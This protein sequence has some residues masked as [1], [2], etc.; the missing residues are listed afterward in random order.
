MGDIKRILSVRILPSKGECFDRLAT[1]QCESCH[2][3]YRDCRLELDHDVFLSFLESMSQA[4]SKALRLSKPCSADT[5]IELSYRR[6][7]IPPRHH[8]RLLIEQLKNDVIHIH[9]N[10]LR[11]E[12]AE[13]TFVQFASGVAEAFNTWATSLETEIITLY[14]TEKLPLDAINPYDEGHQLDNTIPQGFRCRNV[15]ETREHVEGMELCCQL[16]QAGF[17]MLPIAVTPIE[18]RDKTYSGD[19]LPHHRYQR[20]DGFKRYMAFK[21][22]GFMSITSHVYLPPHARPGIQRYS[23]WVIGKTA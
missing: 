11:I 6:I 4:K 7:S 2:V 21:R 14:H 3:H 1:E 18:Y 19:L 16:L 22:L 13:K 9:Y 20:L 17:L 5:F 23:P 8:K 12:M 15:A 10:D